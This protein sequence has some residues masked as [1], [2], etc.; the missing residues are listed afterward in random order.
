MK[1]ILIIV[2]LLFSFSGGLFIS[3]SIN[4]SGDNYIL[5]E[6]KSGRILLENNA[7]TRLPMESTT[8]IMTAFLAIEY[9]N[10]DDY[11]E[12]NEESIDIIGSSIYLEIGEK[13]KMEDLLYGLMLRSGND[14]AV[15]IALH[16]EVKAIQVNVRRIITL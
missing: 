14:S 11:V 4:L 9:G 5:M 8:K 6:E 1:R 16:G 3:E 12:I 10:L 13:I 15:A 2:I 7:Y